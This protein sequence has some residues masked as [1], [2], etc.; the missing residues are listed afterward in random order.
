[1]FPVKPVFTSTLI[2]L[3]VPDPVGVK[4]VYAA[5]DVRSLREELSA[6]VFVNEAGAR[7]NCTDASLAGIRV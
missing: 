4:G 3:T 5:V 1:M 6:T 2:V 7:A